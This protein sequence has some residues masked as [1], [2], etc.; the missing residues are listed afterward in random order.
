[1]LTSSLNADL[2]LGAV[3]HD[4]IAIN[5]LSSAPLTF[6]HGAGQGTGSTHTGLPR[7][8]ED[9]IVHAAITV[10]I[11][12]ITDLYIPL[13][14]SFTLAPAP[15][16]TSLKPLL[17]N[18]KGNPTGLRLPITALTLLIYPGVTVVI[19]AVAA[20][21]GYRLAGVTLTP[22]APLTTLVSPPTEVRAAAD[23]I[24][25]YATITIIIEAVAL[26]CS[27]ERGIAFPPL[28]SLTAALSSTT[29]G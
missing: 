5:T 19:K 27:G 6:T 2:T 20:D 17:T 23:Q 8:A 16:P 15:I 26:L 24:F 12:T 14:G 29:G 4:T 1:M 3:V 10:I 7:C 9:A 18:A 22:T 13:K 28:S 21:L 11:Q 25:I